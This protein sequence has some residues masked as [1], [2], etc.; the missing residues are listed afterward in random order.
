MFVHLL[1]ANLP[2]HTTLGHTLATRLYNHHYLY[3]YHHHHHHHH[4]YMENRNDHHLNSAAA[5]QVR[6]ANPCPC[7]LSR[8][9]E[10]ATKGL[11]NR[12]LLSMATRIYLSTWDK[13]SPRP[14]TR[15]SQHPT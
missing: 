13:P 7:Y 14:T 9:R 10:R 11:A 1:T 12:V 4:Y 8:V 2:T 3:P 15:R 6:G 5:Q